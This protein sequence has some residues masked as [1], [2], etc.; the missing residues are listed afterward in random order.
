LSLS[1]LVVLV[2]ASLVSTPTLARFL[3]SSLPT[4]KKVRRLK[5]TDYNDWLMM[6][7]W[8]LERWEVLR[9]EVMK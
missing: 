5:R 6:G 9:H 4:C 8:L 2:P 1:V 3:L 7:G